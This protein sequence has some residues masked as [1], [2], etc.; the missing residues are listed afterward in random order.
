MR[1]RIEWLK[2][3][4][5]RTILTTNNDVP[6][7]AITHFRRHEGIEIL[8]YYTGG[9]IDF[10]GFDCWL[11]A[12]YRETNAVV[13]FGN[14][15]KERRILWLD[16]HPSNNTEVFEFLKQAVESSGK[17]DYVLD[18]VPDVAA[19]LEKL[20]NAGSD[21]QYHLLITHWGGYQ[22]SQLE[23]GADPV[24]VVI[25]KALR[26]EDIRIPTVVFA[27]DVDAEKRKIVALSLGAV[28][29]CFTFGSLFSRI[30]S[31][32]APALVTG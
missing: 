12:A 11:E 21:E 9:G 27:S 3:I 30:E 18:T 15:L 5:F 22:S 17:S 32:F 13:R 29:Y 7:Q 20:K 8:S 24:V 31:I 1:G 14:Y 19:A 23:G 4:P 28:D 2:G 25:L 10:T 6:E 16:P 26:S